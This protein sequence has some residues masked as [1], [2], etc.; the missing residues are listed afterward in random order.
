MEIFKSI[1]TNNVS[2]SN[3]YLQESNLELKKN[4]FLTVNIEEL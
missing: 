4:E 1:K 2:I 3:V